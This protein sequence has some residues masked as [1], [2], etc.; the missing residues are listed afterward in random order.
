ME[1]IRILQIIRQMNQGGAENFIMNV[2]RNIDKE[3]VQFDFLVYKTGVFDDEIKK[4]GRKNILW[5]VYYRN[6]ST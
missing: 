2:Y 4:N 3:K 6:R 5:K 1:P